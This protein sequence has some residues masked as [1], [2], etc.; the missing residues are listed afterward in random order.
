MVARQAP[1]LPQV[2]PPEVG[3]GV[4]VGEAGV[5]DDP[6]QS[7]MAGCEL[8]GH[9]WYPVAHFAQLLSVAPAFMPGTALH[10]VPGGAGVGAR[11]GGGGGAGVG[12][13]VGGGGPHHL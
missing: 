8:H 3:V 13:S 11:V 9:H 4:G 5:G 12:A 1:Q 10:P 6:E 7:Q 2:P